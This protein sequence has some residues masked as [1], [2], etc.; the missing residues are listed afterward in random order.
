MD[1]KLQNDIAEY[2]K[3]KGWSVAVI[4]TMKVEQRNPNRKYNFEFVVS[5]TGK[6]KDEKETSK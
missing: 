6:K 1:T 5:F 4:G 3:S 2:L